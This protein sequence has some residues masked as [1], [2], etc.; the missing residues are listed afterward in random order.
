MS[1]HDPAL[2]TVPDVLRFELEHEGMLHVIEVTSVSGVCDIRHGGEP[3]GGTVYHP[4]IG[5]R[6]TTPA[7][8]G[9]LP[10]LRAALQPHDAALRSV[11]GRGSDPNLPILSKNGRRGAGLK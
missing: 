5:F 6:F 11:Q 10:A 8:V 2:A 7:V 1:N 9:L 3:L 4:D